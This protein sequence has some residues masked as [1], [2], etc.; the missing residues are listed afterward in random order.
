MNIAKAS[1]NKSSASSML[2]WSIAAIASLWIVAYVLWGQYQTSMNSKLASQLSADQASVE[3]WLSQQEQSL[4]N[5]SYSAIVQNFFTGDKGLNASQKMGQHLK[6]KNYSKTF[7]Y[8]TNGESIYRSAKTRTLSAEGINIARKTLKDKPLPVAM[9]AEAGKGIFMV[10]A[11]Y[12]D[13]MPHELLGYMV[14][15]AP[16]G[17]LGP[18]W[19]RVSLV[20][21]QIGQK[22]VVNGKR[23]RKYKVS[24][25]APVG[26]ND[27][28]Y[29]PLKQPK[30]FVKSQWQGTWISSVWFSL[31]TLIASI[32]TFFGLN[33][34]V[35]IL[36]ASAGQ[37]IKPTW[38]KVVERIVDST[39]DLIVVTDHK[40]I[41]QAASPKVGKVF[42]HQPDELV[43][44]S[45]ALLF[46][47]GK[48]PMV[49]SPDEAV[50][51]IDAK[52]ATCD[53][54]Y[55]QREIN[56][57]SLFHRFEDE[58]EKWQFEA[59]Q[60]QNARSRDF[61]EVSCAWQ[62]ELDH[63]GR[64]T[65]LS[66]HICTLFGKPL[67]AL[68]DQEFVDLTLFA[69]F[70][71]EYRQLSARIHDRKP[72]EDLLFSI[73]DASD[74]I[75]K[76]R[77]NG[78]PTFDSEGNCL[79][80]RGVAL[81]HKE[82]APQ[83]IEE[84]STTDKVR[85]LIRLHLQPIMPM[86]RSAPQMFEGLTQLCTPTGQE[87]KP[88]AYL[89]I[90]ER[91]GGL[92][93]VDLQAMRRVFNESLKKAG[94]YTIN[95]SSESLAKEEFWT[96]VLSL[97][98][99]TGADAS[100][101]VFEIPQAETIKRFSETKDFMQRATETGFKIALDQCTEERALH[102]F[103]RHSKIDYIKLDRSLIAK[104][105]NLAIRSQIAT[106]TREGHA[107]G[108][109]VIACGVENSKDFV[110]LDSIGIDLAQGYY[111]ARPM[112]A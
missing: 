79:G 82:F 12:N 70:T 104:L 72:I 111:L 101:I 17:M 91:K 83:P 92:S 75:R 90:M 47:K 112:S 109:Q 33:K 27:I 62:W 10:K 85:E 103:L 80:F 58:S 36:N 20:Q 74:E 3:L 95:L 77:I 35:K 9:I 39:Q 50:A 18:L 94:S 44:K 84:I 38:Q 11:V 42:G 16:I 15:P 99:E 4:T 61:L 32:A 86:D 1:Y 76:Y 78:K 88:A 41:I 102:A 7:L 65:Y 98:K 52:G 26:K 49:E 59:A 55:T 19:S 8:S 66:E 69:S 28:A 96:S 73:K 30:W 40:N 46:A 93:K 67:G 29:A 106:M 63:S 24:S 6:R 37:L 108:A 97:L 25:A 57:H 2:L 87:I 31:I 13:R 56:S 100:R 51:I 71:N 68:M 14:T 105:D 45:I 81:L 21:Q 48:V 23:I 53:V 5:L 107:R 22:L 89:P 60:K 43:G 54:C 110:Y 34:D 64:V